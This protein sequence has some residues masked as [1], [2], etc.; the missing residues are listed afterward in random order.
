MVRA[1]NG[2]GNTLDFGD[3]LYMSADGVGGVG[4]TGPGGNGTGGLAVL[5]AGDGNS[6]SIA[7]NVALQA[8]GY[9]GYGFGRFRRRQRYGRNGADNDH[10]HRCEPY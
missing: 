10:R 5:S 7:G 3:A 2:A 4:A 6:V 9:G 1:Q 8:E